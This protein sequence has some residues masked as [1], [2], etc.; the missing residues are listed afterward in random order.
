MAWTNHDTYLDRICDNLVSKMFKIS[1]VLCWI[2][3]IVTSV[4][5]MRQVLLLAV[6]Q[7]DFEQLFYSAAQSIWPAKQSS[8]GV[9]HFV[10]Y[11]NDTCRDD[12]SGIMLPAYVFIKTVSYCLSLGSLIKTR[13]LA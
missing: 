8:F 5:R 7:I 13:L 10:G 6:V 12:T 9:E 3:D 1:S 2:N 4:S 11:V